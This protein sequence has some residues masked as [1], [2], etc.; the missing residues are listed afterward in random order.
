MST[1][2]HKHKEDRFKTKW[3]QYQVTDI[4]CGFEYGTVL[5]EI[6][7]VLEYVIVT[8]LSQ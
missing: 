2:N 4:V 6:P 3:T 5:Y 7:F 1:T 8:L